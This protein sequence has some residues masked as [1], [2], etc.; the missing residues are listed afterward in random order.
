MNSRVTQSF[1][2]ALI[3]TFVAAA[4]GD[5]DSTGPQ[6]DA[7]TLTSVTPAQGGAATEIRID[8]SGFSDAVEVTMG[9]IASPRVEVEGGA[10]FALVPAELSVGTT[11]DV[12]VSNE[13]LASA[14]L[15]DAFT[16][17]EPAALR[18]NGV[19]KPIGLVGMTI[20]IEGA[21]FGDDMDLAEGQVFF[22][23]PSGGAIPATVTSPGDDW[24]DGFVVTSVPTGTADTSMV[25]IE[26]AT[27][28]SDS[29]EFRLI[30]SGVFSPS[31]IDWTETTS[32]PQPLTGLGAVFVPIEEG[33][34]AA[35]YVFALGGAG[36]DGVATDVVYRA[37]AQQSGALGSSWST[38]TALPA[39]RAY[40]TTAAA[41]AF[42]AAL[43]TTTTGAYLYVLGGT[44]T[45][46]DVTGT[47]YVGHVDLD[48]SVTGW[49]ETTALPEPLHSAGAVVFRGFIYLVG[50]AGSDDTAVATT[51]RAA[52]NP[53]G[54]LGAWETLDALPSPA[55]YHAL[56]NLGPFI[57]AVGGDAG[58]VAPDV[59]SQSGTE[60]PNVDLVRLD[61]RTGGFSSTGW[62]TTEPMSKSRSKHSS[63]FGGGAL[64]TTSGVYA[65]QPGSSENTFAEI[66]SDGTLEP[67]Q[68]ATGSD[69]IA[70][71]LGI[72]LYNQA[73]VTF[74]DD[75]GTGHV[76][77]LG[78]ADRAD[79]TA[80]DG[81]VFY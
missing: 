1:A 70:S 54:T 33:P 47:T 4:C 78:G 51:Y 59:F 45:S 72:S 48:G 66:Q 36:A 30:Q 42:T 22:T 44:D 27:G 6:V 26:T 28:V 50:G 7:P 69:I 9:G 53:D 21:A 62:T 23:D 40:H 19:S 14:T 55:A 49:Q 24:T 8:G 64:F 74:I 17:V 25:W 3:V 63:I 43:D 29:I 20:I 68:G 12:V 46:G 73:A 76:L 13:G 18:I 71:E 61:L 2:V 37:S 52:V 56:V 16:V 79:G 75:S 15:Q 67:W 35:N 41:T 80:S 10:A 81:V 57:Y 34:A 77:V 31:L 60:R 65:G 58:T 39:P 38:L 11:Y 5:D 32:L